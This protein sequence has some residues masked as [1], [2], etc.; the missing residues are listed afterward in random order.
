M[1][2]DL[3][4]FAAI[5]SEHLAHFRKGQIVLSLIANQLLTKVPSESLQGRWMLREHE[6][7][8]N[9]RELFPDSI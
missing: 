5:D 4:D 6:R 3:A 2:Q 1:P 8:L 7:S 9:S